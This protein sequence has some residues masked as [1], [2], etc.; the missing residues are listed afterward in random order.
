MLRKLDNLEVSRAIDRVI[1]KRPKRSTA[2]STLSP[3]DTRAA[4]D[5]PSPFTHTETLRLS[6]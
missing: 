3:P 2:S 6:V 1:T 5:F 4:R